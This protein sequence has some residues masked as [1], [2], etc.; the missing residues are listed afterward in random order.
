MYMYMYIIHCM[1]VLTAEPNG[2][3]Q[4]ETLGKILTAKSLEEV[5]ILGVALI[6]GV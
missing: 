5:R 3:I 2:D 1:Y 4:Y 6:F